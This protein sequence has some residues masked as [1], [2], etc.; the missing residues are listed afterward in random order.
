[1][2][3][4]TEFYLRF[5]KSYPNSTPEAEARPGW[6]AM[7]HETV[8]RNRKTFKLTVEILGARKIAQWLR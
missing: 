5:L 7:S 8:L 3:V 4:Y 2:S 1:M 6:K